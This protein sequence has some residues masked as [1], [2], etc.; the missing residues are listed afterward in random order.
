MVDAR[1]IHKRPGGRGGGSPSPV[2][3][4]ARALAP[5]QSNR[6]VKKPALLGDGF[7]VQIPH[8]A[9]PSFAGV[10]A[11]VSA[12]VCASLG[13]RLPSASCGRHAL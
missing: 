7:W 5:S 2:G 9:S 4:N 10:D 12:A 6:F 11:G 8:A 3:I 1:L 13:V